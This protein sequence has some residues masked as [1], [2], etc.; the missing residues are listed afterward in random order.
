MNEDVKFGVEG[1]EFDAAYI[2]G[3]NRICSLRR[4][5]IPRDPAP[6]PRRVSSVETFIAA[7]SSLDNTSD[8]DAHD[9]FIDEFSKNT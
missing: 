1:V 2:S 4:R 7:R 8:E 3:S 6:P 9:V 5:P